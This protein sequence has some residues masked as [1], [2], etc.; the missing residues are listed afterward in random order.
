MITVAR[1]T[2]GAELAK[3]LKDITLLDV[4]QAVECLGKSG[5]LFSFHDKPNPDC[6]IGKNIHTVL[7][8]RLAAIQT[9]MEAEL[10]QTNLA[11]VVAAAEKEIQQQ[12]VFQ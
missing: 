7:D 6:P 3:D 8:D 2:G 11:Q 12:A 9:A 10:A 5:Q 4:Y 1:G